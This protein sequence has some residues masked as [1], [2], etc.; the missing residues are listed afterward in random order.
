MQGKINIFLCFFHFHLFLEFFAFCNC[1]ARKARKLLIKGK[2]GLLWSPIHPA[3]R[4][5][6]SQCPA[7]AFR[8]RF[9]RL[10]RKITGTGFPECAI[11]PASLVPRGRA[12]G[13]VLGDIFLWKAG[14]AAHIPGGCDPLYR[15]ACRA[16]V[17]FID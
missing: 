1:L 13:Q 6:P 8:D 17:Y 9:G 5:F 10:S 3:S 4:R 14:L 12:Q 11:F 16:V 2:R 7:K 15:L